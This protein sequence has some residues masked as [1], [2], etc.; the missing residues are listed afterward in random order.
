MYPPLPSA[1]DARSGVA[2]PLKATLMAIEAI[3]NR[4]VEKGDI[5]RV[6]RENCMKAFELAI[7]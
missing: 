5:R 6:L 7:S 4:G 3:A 2:H 1:P